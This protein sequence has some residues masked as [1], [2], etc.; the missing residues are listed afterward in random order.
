MAGAFSLFLG[1]LG[2]GAAGGS[3]RG[4]ERKN[5]EGRLSVWR[6]AWPSWH[7]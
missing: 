3:Q 2:L 7:L 1:M 5:Q 6:G 4:T